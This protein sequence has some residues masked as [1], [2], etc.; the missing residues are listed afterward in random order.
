MA[1]TKECICG[2]Q[3]CEKHSR[4]KAK[5]ML[6]YI[7]K[8]LY[9]KERKG[10]NAITEYCY[11]YWNDKTEKDAIDSLKRHIYKNK[12]S[13]LRHCNVVIY[14]NHETGQEIERE[15]FNHTR[16]GNNHAFAKA[17]HP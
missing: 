8:Q 13:E 10:T 6:T 15:T 4:Y 1:N 16:T 5:M 2:K 17:Q 9:I 14:Y 3:F 11:I 12:S 7:G